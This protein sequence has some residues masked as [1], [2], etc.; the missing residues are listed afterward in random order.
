MHDSEFIIWGKKIISH[1]LMF[2][3]VSIKFMGFT[4]I[5]QHF[6]YYLYWLIDPCIFFIKSMIL[7]GP[8]MEKRSHV[9]IDQP[10]SI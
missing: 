6:M 1:G 4:K 3:N 2:D 5:N 10:I 8:N 7:T 9:C